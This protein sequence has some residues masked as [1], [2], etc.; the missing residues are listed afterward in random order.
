MKILLVHSYYQQRGGEDSVFEQ[1]YELLQQSEETK[2][3]TFRNLGGWRGAVQFIL[4]IWNFGAAAKVR[5]LINE[6]KPD[7]IQIYNWHY[8]SGPAIIHAA[9][10][11]G[12]KIVINVPNYRLLCPSGSLLHKGKLFTCSIQKR[13]FPWKAVHNK[14]YRNSFFQTFWLAFVVY[15]HKK[16][17][18]WE[19]VDQYIVPSNTV[20]NLFTRYNSYINIPKDRFSVKPNF[21]I[22]TDKL[23]VKRGRHFLFVGR[24]SEE[25][26]IHLLVDSFENSSYELIIAGSGPLKNMVMESCSRH[27][28]ITF[29]GN[30]DKEKVKEAMSIC[31]A[32]IFSS[33]W[34]EPF[35]L[36]ITEA[37]SNGCPVIASDMGSPAELIIEGVTGI[38]FSAG[39]KESLRNRLDYWQNLSEAEQEVYR[40]NCINCFN[41]LFTPAKNLK[42]LLSIYRLVLNNGSDIS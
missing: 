27:S 9:K 41:E 2:A 11:L 34:Y 35:G 12:V 24:L 17:G 37:L 4:S 16:I 40:L 23:P 28:N 38:H 22:Q 13:G 36:V 14:V 19:I 5:E 42:Q 15:Y 6:F 8:S 39:D 10:K 18:T 32:L 26:G 7:I 20:L 30:L 21:S 1:E 33:I 25:K 29:A 3:L 31:T